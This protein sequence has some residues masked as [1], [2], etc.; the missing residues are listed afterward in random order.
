[1]GVGL[2]DICHPAN[3]QA[4]Y[5]LIFYS[6][7]GYPEVECKLVIPT[8]A[9]IMAGNVG[10]VHN[11]HAYAIEEELAESVRLGQHRAFVH[12]KPVGV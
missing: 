7:I 10:F 5:P 2:D 1:M 11:G 12:Q 9:V 4:F 8:A 3:V 6:Q